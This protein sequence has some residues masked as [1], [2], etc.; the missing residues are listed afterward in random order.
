M[1]QP[2]NYV[3]TQQLSEARAVEAG[4][5][6]ETPRPAAADV[7]APPETPRLGEMFVRGA[8]ELGSPSTTTA[9]QGELRNELLDKGLAPFQ[10][11]TLCFRLIFSPNI[12][13]PLGAPAFIKPHS[14]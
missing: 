4:T 2:D 8:V 13:T 5:P 3:E 9:A 11:C 7:A 1:Q 10:A 14:A 12:C 6:P